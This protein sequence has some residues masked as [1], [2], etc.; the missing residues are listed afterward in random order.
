[1]CQQHDGWSGVCL[2]VGIWGLL[3]Q[4]KNVSLSS[5]TITSANFLAELV[6]KRIV[7]QWLNWV[8]LRLCLS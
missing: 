8:V 1:M 2:G 3:Y 5:K 4:K 6:I 7:M